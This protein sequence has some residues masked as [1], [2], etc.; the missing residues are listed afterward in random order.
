MAHLQQL[1]HNREDS[2]SFPPYPYSYGYRVCTSSG[3]RDIM[4]YPCSMTV[5]RINY[6]SNPNLTYNG[7]P[8]GNSSTAD[9][10][11]SLN[12][13]AAKVAAYRSGSV[14]SSTAPVAP[15]SLATSSV[16]Y[17]KVS[18]SW[19]DK[20]SNEDGFKVQRSK[21][22]VAYTL[23]ATLG[24]NVLSFADTGVTPLTKYYYRVSAYNAAGNSA[25]SNVISATTPGAPPTAPTSVAAING[26]NGTA[27]ITW[28][29]KS[30][31][32]A[33][34]DI[35]RRKWDSVTQT[36]LSAITVGSVGANVTR[37]VNSSGKG[38]FRYY[39]RAVNSYGTSSWVGP[40]QV[41][42]TGG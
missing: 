9:G 31:N 13:T 35:R 18:L 21:D 12:E 22:G 36:W 15:T 38:T 4:A 41:T 6:F 29:D 42:V 39:V 1:D 28:A 20:S 2:A 23:I 37:Y 40:A 25:Y 24:A 10:A 14:P 27:T 7:Y 33:R 32:Q 26:G 30:T 16:R 17:N 34:F 19:S 11:R 8:I 3:F 5:A